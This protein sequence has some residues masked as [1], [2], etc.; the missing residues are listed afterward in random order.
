M[1]AAWIG[2]I[3]GLSVMDLF[4]THADRYDKWFEKER[5]RRLFEIEL[6]CINRLI[7]NEDCKNSL[8]I[9]VGT[10]RFADSLGIGYGVD[11]SKGVLEY[12]KKRGIGV[13]RADGSS[14]PWRSG[15]FDKVFLIFTLCF[16]ENPAGILNGCRT[17]LREDGKLIL[18]IVPRDSKWG[19]YYLERAGEGNI[20][21][22]NARFYSAKEVEGMLL[23]SG[24][25]IEDTYSTL[26]QPPEGRVK[27]EICRKGYD[28]NAGFVSF[29]ARSVG[30]C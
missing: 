19:R 15:A 3:E 6:G 14:L 10:G 12:A 23:S 2:M 30:E 21:Y 16:A 1:K 9:G 29:K 26:R 18:G 8:E 17:V 22:K 20:F 7:E 4:D 11:I 25:E 24:F 13:V 5:G 27:P 28:K